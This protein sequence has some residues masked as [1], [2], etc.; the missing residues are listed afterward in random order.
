[1]KDYTWNLE[2]RTADGHEHHYNEQDLSRGYRKSY[3]KTEESARKAL[4][5]QIRCAEEFSNETVIAWALYSTVHGIGI[6][7]TY[8]A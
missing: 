6:I 8:K 7:E 4:Q 1:M 3:Y 5:R 2:V